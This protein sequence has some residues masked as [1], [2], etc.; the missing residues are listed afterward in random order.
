MNEIQENPLINYL[1]LKKIAT[2]YDPNEI[3]INLILSFVLGLII[4]T[5]YKK[6]HKGLSYSQSFMVTNIF[7]TVIVCMVIMIIGNNLARAFALVGALSI[8][9]FRTV[10]KDPKDLTFIFAVLTLGMGIGSGLYFLSISAGF[11]FVTLTVLMKNSRVFALKDF[12]GILR[13]SMNSVPGNI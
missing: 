4:S 3:I 1:E 5:V 6:T 10:I 11:I 8:I 9:R 7:V 12:D 2:I 13:V